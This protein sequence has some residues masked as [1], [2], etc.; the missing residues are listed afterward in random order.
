MKKTVMICDDE[1]DLLTLFASA[2][3][4]KYNVLTAESGRSCLSKYQD[5]KGKGNAIDVLLLDYRLGDMLG[6]YVACKIREFD[7]TKTIIISAYDLEKTFIN[8]LIQ[9]NCIMGMLKK[10]ISIRGLFEKLE[11]LT[12]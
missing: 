6:D 3:S 2:L 11:E 12:E 1:A 8:D 10:P 5:E 4:S 7:G 9:K